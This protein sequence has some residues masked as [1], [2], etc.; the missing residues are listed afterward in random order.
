MR[1]DAYGIVIA[2]GSPHPTHKAEHIPQ[3]LKGYRE[4]EAD[5]S[6]LFKKEYQRKPDRICF[7]RNS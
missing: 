7:F 2:Y 1:P 5:L 4:F 3:G 6:A